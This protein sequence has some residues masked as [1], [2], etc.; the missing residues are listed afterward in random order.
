V[1]EALL[2]DFCIFLN[3]FFMKFSKLKEFELVT[4]FFFFGLH[5]N[6]K[7]RLGLVTAAGKV[8]STNSLLIRLAGCSIMDSLADLFSSL[9]KN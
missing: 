8:G 1:G 7:S 2:S 4:H 9:L 3:S 5:I 6:T